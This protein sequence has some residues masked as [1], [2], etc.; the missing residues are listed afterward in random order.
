MRCIKPWYSEKMRMSL[1][2]GKCAFCIKKQINAWCLRIS[3]EMET[4]SSAFFLTL[5]YDDDHLPEFG[6]L[7]K[8]DLQ[9]F[10]K[11]LRK[12]N[13][14]L[15]YFAVGEYGSNYKRPHY[16]AIIFNLDTLDLVT[17]AW[18]DV[19]GK[20]IG[21][22]SGSR[23]NMG[24]IRYMVSYMALPQDVLHRQPPFRVMSRNPGIGHEYVRKNKHFHLARSDGTVNV[25]GTINAMPRY[26][27][28]KIFIYPCQK[29]LMHIKAL[30]YAA[31]HPQKPTQLQHDMLVQKLNRKNK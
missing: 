3:H 12:R 27:K 9:L 18:C 26:Y 13:P 11:R 7:S 28:D 22:V 8:R 6:E 21:F 5:T 1:P 10:I 29:V 2:C 23:A 30:K 14:G 15:R 31:A 19:D 20:P 16:H 17:K 24:R 25:L 4:S